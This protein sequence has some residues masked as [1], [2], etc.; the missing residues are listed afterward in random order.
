MIRFIE[1]SSP[2]TIHDLNQIEQEINVSFPNEF[3]EHYLVYNGGYPEQDTY[4]WNDGSSTTINTFSSIKYSGYSNLEESY[5]DLV[6]AKKYLPIGIIPFATDD[7]GNFF[8]I[9][10]RTNDY[11]YVYYCNN[12]HYNIENKEECLI[13]IEKS[14][15][16]FIQKLS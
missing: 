12:D 8:C 2:L 3:K 9:S 6:L 11:G 15:N 16:D 5:K 14:F 13:L 1:I 10:A 7:G 4:K